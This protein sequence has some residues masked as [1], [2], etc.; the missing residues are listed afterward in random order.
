MMKDVREQ[1]RVMQILEV[2][3]VIDVT[4]FIKD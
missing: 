3:K 1:G 2:I 4:Q